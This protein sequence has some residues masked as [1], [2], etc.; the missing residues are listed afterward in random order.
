MDDRDLLLAP[1]HQRRFIVH[2]ARECE[3]EFFTS[4]ETMVSIIDP[5]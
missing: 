3:E 1:A 2:E 4:S 5:V